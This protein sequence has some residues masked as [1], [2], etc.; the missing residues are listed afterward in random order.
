ME[1]GFGLLKCRP[2]HILILDNYGLEL[3]VLLERV[4]FLHVTDLDINL[5][6]VV[7]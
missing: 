2:C 5:V 7:D 1:I 3:L 4:R 6:S